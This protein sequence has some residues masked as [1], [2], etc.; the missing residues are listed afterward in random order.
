MNEM[1]NSE[2]FTWLLSQDT[3]SCIHWF[4]KYIFSS[5]K[6]R[7]KI[8]GL[9]LVR[10]YM[11]YAKIRV[12]YIYNKPSFSLMKAVQYTSVFIKPKYNTIYYSLT[13]RQ[14]VSFCLFIF[15]LIYIYNVKGEQV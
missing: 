7:E 14:L 13:I 12:C 2:K 8:V 6:V 3:K 15:L 11:K 5:R 10:T 9:F 1:N 4:S